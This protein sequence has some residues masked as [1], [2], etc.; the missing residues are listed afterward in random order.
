MNDQPGRFARAAIPAKKPRLPALSPAFLTEEDAAYWVHA[1]IPDNVDKEYASVILLRPDGKFVATAPIPGEVSS[2]DL[3]TIVGIDASGHLIAPKGYTFAANL[4]SHPRRHDVYRKLYPDLDETNLRRFINFFSSSDFIGDVAGQEVFPSAYLSGPDGTLLKYSP[5]GS[6]A[7]FD[8]YRWHEAGSPPDHPHGTY[9]VPAIIAR[10]AAVGELKVIVSSADWGHD[11]GRVPAHWRPGQAFARG[12]VTELSLMT[13]VCP[14]AERAVLAALKPKGAQTSG[15]LLRNRAGDEYVATLARPAGLASWDPAQLFPRGTDG[16]LKLPAG[17]VLEGFYYASR[18][19]P[20]HFAPTQHWLYENFF[21]PQEMAW[22]IACRG[23]SQALSAAGEPLSLYMLARDAA[24][25]KYTFSGSQIEAALSVPQPDGTIGDGGLQTRLLNGAMRP[26]DFF[27]TL[28]LAGKLQVLRGS[29]LWARLGGLDLEWT[30]FANFTW[31][32]L[33]R[34]FLSADDAARHAHEQIDKRRDRQY[35]GYVLQR[36]DG[37]FVVTEPLEGGIAALSHATFLPSDNNGRAVFPDD[38]VLHAR[39]VCHEALSRLDPLTVERLQWTREEAL[40]SQQ[41]LSVEETRQGLIDGIALYLS[42]AQNSLLRYEPAQSKAAQD[43]ANRLGTDK[44]PGTLAVALSSGATR[45]AEFIRQ[46]AAAGRLMIVIDHDMWGARGQ[47]LPT[48]AV[49]APV[50]PSRRPEPLMFGAVFASADEAAHNQYSRDNRRHDQ[51]RVRFGFIL[52]HK[53][54]DDY[55]ATELVGV[56]DQRNNVFQLQAVFGARR[57]PPWYQFPDGFFPHA[58]VYSCQR[59][60]S[61]AEGAAAWLAQ[62][63]IAPQDLAISV[64]YARRRPVAESRA[65]VA[66]YLSTQDGALLKYEMHSASKLFDDYTPELTLET[67]KRHL[68]AGKLLPEEFVRMVAAS[69]E[70]AVMRTSRCW[71]RTG[72]VTMDWQPAAHPQ[73]RELT[74]VF[75]SPDD[76]AVYA[77]GLVPHLTQATQGGVILKRADGWYVATAPI[78]VSR[79]DFDI[80]EIFPDDNPASALFPAGCEVIAR[81]RSRVAREFS[82]LLSP[83]QK[84]LYLNMLS[85]DTLYS[86]FTRLREQH[87]SEYLFAPDGS[88]IRYD[89][90]VWEQLF[91]D[92]LFTLTEYQAVPESFDAKKIKQCIRSGELQ[93]AAWVDALAKSGH[94]YVVTGSPLWGAPRTVDA[95]VTPAIVLPSASPYSKATG[96]PACSPAFIQADAAARYVHQAAVSRETQTFGFICRSRDAVYIASLAVE[97]QGSLLALDRVYAQG[98][99]TAGFALHSIYLRAALLFPGAPNDDFQHFCIPPNDVQQACVRANT[100]QG[101]LPIYFSCAD[102]ALLRLELHAFEPG[103]FYDRFG[104]IE[105][106]PNAFVALAQAADDERELANGT[107]DFPA[108]VRRMALAGKLEV[109]ETSHYWSRHGRIDERWQP[110]MAEASSEEQW[111]ASHEPALGPVFHHSDDAARYAQ[112]RIGSE[113][114]VETGYAGAIL[115]QLASDRFIPLEPLAYSAFADSPAIRIFRKANDPS[116]NWRHPAPRYPEGYSLVASHQFHLSGNTT[117][118]PDP[119]AI[120]GYFP[121]PAQVHAHTH[122]LTAQGFGIRDCYFSSP[123]GALLK[124][125]PV[126]TPAERRLLL[127]KPVVFQGGRWVGRLSPGAFVSRLMEQGDLRVLVAGH[128]WKQVGQMGSAWRT[129]RQQAQDFEVVAERDEL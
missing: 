33:S 62:Y 101:Y 39:Y 127:T 58:C 16:S 103:E 10:F 64:Y 60:E 85:V 109:I 115:A 47:V 121:A 59:V 50:M 90:G 93:P 5:S 80:S 44:H 78:E 99:L 95:W 21:S 122:E 35:A 125:T 52:K 116:S 66:L 97:V 124:Y 126:Y 106:R 117:L 23:N 51:A 107:F 54:R 17:Y 14:S 114:D 91:V 36:S 120:N 88:F 100:P 68:A 53:D 104:Q 41:M 108:Y 29:P 82:V 81:Y 48:W 102:G 57:S 19:D 56:S 4:H 12:V 9:D 71:D 8:Y 86:A 11:V 67:I 32:P 2:F 6:A 112:Q 31:P 42:G 34:D 83:V 87:L 128:Y 129:R 113:P 45:P 28:V 70:L 3:S 37:R 118:A 94:L 76:A 55:V 69:G 46:Q 92:F 61:A 24:L 105:L 27:T 49:P 22:A 111:V 123:D 1:R 65:L 110:R 89:A 25:L 26:R 84:Q 75:Q 73:R 13:R 43:L 63:F 40:L 38:H 7:E 18:P 30:P 98:Q 119:E 20:A 96:A 79:E 77:R 72:R 15:L 74:P